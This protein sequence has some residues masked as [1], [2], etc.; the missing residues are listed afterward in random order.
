MVSALWLQLMVVIASLYLAF[1]ASHLGLLTALGQQSLLPAFA[2]A[3]PFSW[4]GQVHGLHCSLRRLS[5]SLNLC[6]L[7]TGMTRHLQV[8]QLSG[9][10]NL[11]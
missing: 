8:V 1:L 4:M 9:G 3:V 7:V 2:L 6:C 5:L 10:P 11:Q